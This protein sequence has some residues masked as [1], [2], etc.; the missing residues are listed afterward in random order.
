[1]EDQK[2]GLAFNQ[3]WHLTWILLKGEGLNQKLKFE[4]VESGRR[5]EKTNLTQTFD[6]RVWGRSPQPLGKFL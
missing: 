6:R 5:V 3:D 4:N 2:P 1:M